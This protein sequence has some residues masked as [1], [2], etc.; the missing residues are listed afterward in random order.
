VTDQPGSGSGSEAPGSGQ[1]GSE[2]PGPAQGRRD[3][4]E[5][6]P[7]RRPPS[8]AAPAARFSAPPQAHKFELTPARAAQIVRQSSNARWVGFLAV[9]V[10]ILFVIVYYFYELGAPLG[11][12]TA[13]LV[14]QEDAQQVASVE[15]GYNLFEANC[16]R[17]HGPNGKGTNEGYIAPPLNDQMKLF[18][19]LNPG[20]IQTVLN[21]GGRYVCGNPNSIMPVW[22]DTNGGPLN[23]I[24]IQDLI[25]FLRA[26]SNHTYEVRSATTDEPIP[27]PSNPSQPLTF[28]GWVDPNFKPDPSATPVPDCYLGNG[29]AAGGSAAPAASLPANAVT[30]NVTASQ[31]AFDVKTLDAPANAAFAIHFVNQDAGI[32]HN[33]EIRKSDGTTVVQ[34]NP[35]LNTT[36]E[37]TYV[38]NPLAAGTYEFICKIHP[39][40]AMTGTLTVK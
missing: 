37:I 40:P 16:A 22:A 15:R 29:A 32:P 8:E 10:V 3:P 30:L 13:R 23:Y 20:Y 21:V 36:G 1:P 6:L 12:S 38:I 31:I 7:A 33:V 24:Q 26:P 19:H 17:C 11:L 27:D 35:V 14:Q 9:C 5:R 25:N 39:I 18:V 4:A 34:D 2:E 28:T